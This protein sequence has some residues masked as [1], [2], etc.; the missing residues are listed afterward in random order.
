[1]LL[2]HARS[3]LLRLLGLAI[4]GLLTVAAAP[5][6]GLAEDA[7][8]AP[9]IASRPALA[10]SGRLTRISDLLKAGR[11]VKILTI[12]SS[13]TAGT[14]ATSAAAAYPARLAE[15]IRQR[16]PS[17]DVMVIA[18]GIAGE[19]GSQTL[20]RLSVEVESQ[21]PDLVIWQVGTNDALTGVQ[22][23]DFRN[24]L[25]RGVAAATRFDADL[26]LLDQQFYPTIRKKDRYERFVAI[27]KEVGLQKR[28]CVFDRY[29]LM[30]SWSER[31]EEMFRAMLASDGFHMSDRGYACMARA[32]ADEI[33]RAALR[34]DDLIAF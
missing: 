20:A 30:K 6:R 18:S 5:H 11:R 28:A 16:L 25:E 9:C 23:A 15:E 21:K 31:S 3:G 12:G 8:P 32:L 24:L 1:M 22:A 29:T 34:P 10:T 17:A 4:G 26:I 19:T 2:P 27:V 7:S 14:G 13:S 33:V